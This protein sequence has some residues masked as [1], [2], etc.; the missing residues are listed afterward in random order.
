VTAP[1]VAPPQRVWQTEILPAMILSRPQPA[2]SVLAKQTGIQGEVVL[3]TIIDREGRVARLE[4]ISGHP[5][6]VKAAVDAVL[7][8]RYRPTMLNGR[9]VE[10]ETTI[11][12]GFVLAR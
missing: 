5:L 4:V 2:Y 6:L 11:H 7:T 9:P 1:P 3:H 10:V 12:V 8:W